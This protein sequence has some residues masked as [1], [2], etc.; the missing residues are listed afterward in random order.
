MVMIMDMTTITP[1][2]TPTR[3]ITGITTIIITTTRMTADATLY[4]LMTWLSPSYPVGAFS[5]SHGLEYAVEAGLVRDRDGLVD[6]VATVLASGGAWNDA[7]L[8]AA[9]WRAHEDAARL[10]EIAELAAAFRGT[11]ELALE[12]RAQGAAFLAITAE[13]WPAPALD[14]FAKE[15]AG[16]AALPVAVG[17]AAATHGLG[18]ETTLTAYLQAFAANQISAAI[19]SVPLGQRD[20]QRAQAALE[21]IVLATAAR[22]AASDLDDL[23][24]ATPMVDWCSMR[25]ETQYTRLFRS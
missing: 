19:R 16:E 2:P 3:M 12:T 15:H 9:A 17:L 13:A 11:S 10:T 22:A 14:V 7:V 25:H 1:T 21:P 6:W 18:L 24:A 20:G 8:L 5:Y 4:R 23:G